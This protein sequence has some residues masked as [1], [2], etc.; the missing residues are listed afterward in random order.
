MTWRPAR[1]SLRVMVVIVLRATAMQSPDPGKA[2]VLRV[3]VTDWGVCY[4]R[5]CTPWQEAGPAK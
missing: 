3:M 5:A 4:T 2:P 1:G